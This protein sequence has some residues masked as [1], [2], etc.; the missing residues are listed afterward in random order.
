MNVL[1]IC[2]QGKNRSRTAAALFSDRFNTRSAGLYSRNSVNADQ[3][4]WADVVIVMEDRHR[5][6][7]AERFPT[8]YIQKRIL[9]TGIPDIYRHGQ[10]ELVHLLNAK[11]PELL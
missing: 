11:I 4:L 8:V 2:N 6:E 9:V 5:A 1:F 7:I 3:L 10:P